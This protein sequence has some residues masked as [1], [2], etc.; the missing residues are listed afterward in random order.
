MNGT[1]LKW[2]HWSETRIRENWAE[3]GGQLS[4]FLCLDCPF[5]LPPLFQPST[6]SPSK[7]PN[8][9]LF[10]ISQP[11]NFF[12]FWNVAFFHLHYEASTSGKDP[13]A[14]V[15]LLSQIRSIKNHWILKFKLY[16]RDMEGLFMTHIHTP[17][18]K[19]WWGHLNLISFVQN[20]YLISFSTFYLFS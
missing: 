16:K 12:H 20:M 13:H 14:D 2:L 5:F 4:P 18:A 1:K 8:I 6:I 17:Q 10:L 11:P 15:S 19:S 3:L 9:Y 7:E